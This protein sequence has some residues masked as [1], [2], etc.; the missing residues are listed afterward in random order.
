MYVKK[1]NLKADRLSTSP[2]E[3]IENII[4]YL[5]F[6]DKTQLAHTNKLMHQ[7]IESAPTGCYTSS[8]KSLWE[9]MEIIEEKENA[10]YSQINSILNQRANIRRKIMDIDK[11]VINISSN[12][13]IANFIAELTVN[14]LALLISAPTAGAVILLS[15]YFS[16]DGLTSRELYGTGMVTTP[17]LT[18]GFL[19]NRFFSYLFNSANKNNI[20]KRELEADLNSLPIIRPESRL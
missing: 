14:G 7:T 5:C 13:L 6:K 15:E 12:S 11:S 9:Q 2:K 20:E 1:N 16:K 18:I 3:I 10:T 17:I 8:Y 4:T 19:A